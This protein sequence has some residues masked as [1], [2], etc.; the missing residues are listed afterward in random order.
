MVKGRGLN[1]GR[2]TKH[3]KGNIR[4]FSFVESDPSPVITMFKGYLNF[5]PI[6]IFITTSVTLLI[7][8]S[9]VRFSTQLKNQSHGFCG[10]I[11][12]E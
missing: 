12:R 7:F 8:K 5:P 3:E 9:L 11:K 6:N 1:L 4:Y 10:R 2:K